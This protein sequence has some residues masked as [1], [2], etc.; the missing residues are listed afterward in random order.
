MMVINDHPA[1][2]ERKFD[3]RTIVMRETLLRS[4]ALLFG[5]AAGIGAGGMLDLRSIAPLRS[6]AA[7]DNAGPRIVPIPLSTPLTDHFVYPPQVPIGNFDGAYTEATVYKSGF[8]AGN[9]VAFWASEAGALRSYSFP[10]DEF[11]YVLEG[12]VVTT[13][14]DGTKHEFHPGDAFVLP[15]G[16]AGVW[17]MKSRFKKMIVNF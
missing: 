5:L 13:E 15:K 12:T 9:R 2:H 16:W 6:A 10:K 3:G 7:A 11:V 17:D 14:T 1:L 8:Y 4:V